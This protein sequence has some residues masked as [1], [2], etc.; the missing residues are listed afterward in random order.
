VYFVDGVQ[1][2]SIIVKSKTVKKTKITNVSIRNVLA[3][4][5]VQEDSIKQALPQ[6]NRADTLRVLSDGREIR[7]TDMSRLYK[8]N[9]EKG[10]DMNII[11]EHLRTL[12]EVLYAEPDGISMPCIVPDDTHYFF[13]Q[14][15]MNNLANPGCDIHA[16]AAWD[17]YTGNP[18]NI[19]A[20][21]DGGVVIGHSDLNDKITGGDTGTG[22]GDWVSHGT[23]VAGIAAAESNNG[24][25]V[26]GVDWNAR[27][28]PQRIDF[29]GDAE[30]YQAIIDAVN[31]SP[32]VFVLN[33]SYGLA[34]EDMSPGRYSTTIR[35][36]VAYAYKN[37][38]IFVAAMGNHQNTYPDV[39]NYPAGYPNVIAV[40]STSS[41]DVIAGSSVHGNYIDVCAPGVGIYSTISGDTYG[42]MSGTSM[43]TP[44]VAGFASLL[45][46][47]NS[48]LANDDV[49]NIIRLSADKTLGMN[50]QDYTVAYGYGRINVNRAL[51][52]LTNPYALVQNTASSGTVVSTSNQYVAQFISA[53]G[54]P[55]GNYLVKRIEVQKTVTLP[56]NVYNVIGAW[57]RGVFTSGWSAASPN[58]G[59]GF[60]EIVPGSLTSTSVTLRTYIYQVW[61]IVGS[62][63]GYYPTSPSNATFAYSVLGLE[64]PT[65][66]GPSSFSGQATYTLQN[67]PA[68]ATVEWSENDCVYVEF[69]SQNERGDS[70]VFQS[71]Y[72]GFGIIYA[73]VTINN[74]DV[75]VSRYVYTD[76]DLSILNNCYISAS[77]FACGTASFNMANL[78]E[79]DSEVRWSCDTGVG[80]TFGYDP[81]PTYS[82]YTYTYPTSRPG[83]DKMKAQITYKGKTQ[84]WEHEFNFNFNR[85]YVYYPVGD[86]ILSDYGFY[87]NNGLAAID[88]QYNY[89]FSWMSSEWSAY[90]WGWHFVDG[91]N[92][93]AT[94]EGPTGVPDIMIELCFDTP[95]GGRTCY[96]REFAVPQSLYGMSASA[97]SLSPN[98]ASDNVTINLAED[99]T[100]EQKSKTTMVTATSSD[101]SYEIQLWNPFGLVKQVT[102]DQ[103]NYQLS[104]SGIPAGFYYVHVIK[105]KMTYRKQLIIK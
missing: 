70:A 75:V 79:F 9:L 30:T 17:I 98:P 67:L 52:Y 103:S 47:Y 8:I 78:P 101:D 55:T 93:F 29:G 28:H 81:D 56:D 73:T 40:G 63:M 62:Y 89:P 46:G 6:F 26:T 71:N 76:I 91:S 83:V 86:T 20:I 42:Y 33:N 15:N 1:A 74:T 36:A 41:N 3:E 104:L 49:E 43:A 68:G 21:V 100:R 69:I 45:K 102:T 5:N 97:F 14:W 23:H 35:Q 65:I 48:S 90:G 13:H 11:I 16:E 31:Y 92:E 84:D 66:S 50:G 61:S 7:Q 99:A 18:N 25:G 22:S 24:Q 59:E 58:F 87:S 2:E 94:F 51:S 19:I 53:P 60:C 80:Y 32:N 10:K 34:F 12:P 54:L 88:V 37:N 4:I 39:I 85:P 72:Y 77:D 57:G 96:Q 105:N 44:H 27:I 95:C 64:K 38:R 82:F